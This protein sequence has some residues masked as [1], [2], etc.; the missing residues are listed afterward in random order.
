MP[1]E[2][3]LLNV[4]TDDY[5]FDFRFLGCFIKIHKFLESPVSNL[6]DKVLIAKALDMPGDKCPCLVQ[7]G[8]TSK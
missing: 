5:A 3:R 4:I 8:K 6:S 2:A 1:T 7:M